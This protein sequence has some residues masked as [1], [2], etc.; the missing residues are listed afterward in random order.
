MENYLEVECMP[1]KINQVFMNIINNASEAIPEK[2]DIF[3]TTSVNTK[4]D[5]CKNFD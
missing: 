4:S 1:G 2:G 3:I 5:T